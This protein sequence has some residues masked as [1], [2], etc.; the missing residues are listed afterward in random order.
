V[1]LHDILVLRIRIPGSPSELYANVSLMDPDLTP[2]LIDFLRMQQEIFKTCKQAH[3]LQFKK[4][5]FLLKFCVKIS[6]CR[7]YFSPLNK[8]MR[9]GNDPYGTSD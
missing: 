7:H 2:F 5:N 3:H 9:K 1:G 6:F 4:F 8:F